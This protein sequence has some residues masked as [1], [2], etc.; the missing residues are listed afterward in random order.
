MDYGR[1]QGRVERKKDEKERKRPG[2]EG[3]RGGQV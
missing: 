2:S 1:V 3:A